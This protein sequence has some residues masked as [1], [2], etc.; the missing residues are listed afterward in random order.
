MLWL[1]CSNRRANRNS[2]PGV[3]SETSR[4]IFPQQHR[5]FLEGLKMLARRLLVVEDHAL[6][7]SLLVS[8]L[9]GEGFEVFAA[10]DA[11]Q[12]LEMFS[13]LDPDGVVL[14]INLGSGANGLELA[15][16]L[17]RQNE[18]LPIV[19]LTSI[20]DVRLVGL[21][22]AKIPDKVAFLTKSSLTDLEVLYR[23]IDLLISG[24]ASQ[25]HSIAADG[26]S[27]LLKKLT[28]NQLM[29]LKYLADGLSNAEIAQSMGITARAVA[30]T[31]QRISQRFGVDHEAHPRARSELVKIYL[32]HLNRTT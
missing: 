11:A 10:G 2:E 26:T 17:R 23:A 7:R 6:T 29:V 31:V 8:A 28:S 32:T 14:D 21:A 12:G 19:F 1:V 25:H 9:T 16:Q 24:G 30:G 20:P 27:E 22:S 15:E 3:L 4:S 13:A 5:V 18:I